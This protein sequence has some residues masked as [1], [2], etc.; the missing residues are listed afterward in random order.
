MGENDRS[1]HL[2][3]IDASDTAVKVARGRRV[4]PVDA[5]DRIEA[6]FA[7]WRGARG[8]GPYEDVPGWCRSLAVTE[9]AAQDYDVLP[10]RGVGGTE[11]QVEPGDEREKVG[12]LTRELY[13]LFGASHRLE[14]ELRDLL[15]QR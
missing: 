7:A 13:G 9:I 1:G 6:T 5:R 4:L 8:H 12:E 15:D 3:L 10:S 14:D 11:S 2:L